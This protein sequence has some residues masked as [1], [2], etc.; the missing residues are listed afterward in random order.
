MATYSILNGRLVR[1]LKAVAENPGA[2]SVSMS[3]ILGFDRVTYLAYAKGLFGYGLLD[4]IGEEDSPRYALSENGRIALGLID[5]MVE[6][7]PNGVV[8]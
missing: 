7:A 1:V 8:G 6:I 4:R 3:R 2:G 5:R